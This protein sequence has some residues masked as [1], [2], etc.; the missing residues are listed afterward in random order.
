LRRASSTEGVQAQAWLQRKPV[1]ENKTHTHKKRNKERKERK[2]GRKEG[3]K[4]ERKKERKKGRKEGRK[5]EKEEGR[6]ET[7]Q[8]QLEFKPGKECR[9]LGSS[10]LFNAFIVQNSF[11]FNT[12]I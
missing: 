5:K 1:S 6:E 7:H 2:E 4:E 11:M 9:D 8:S 12:F 3:R 10:F